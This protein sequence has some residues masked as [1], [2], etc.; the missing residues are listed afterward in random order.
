MVHICQRDASRGEDCIRL[1][2]SE[3][4]ECVLGAHNCDVNAL[5]INT[6]GSY[7]CACNRGFIGD[8]A[9]CTG[10]GPRLLSGTAWIS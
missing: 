2:V 9:N 5:C 1:H 8:G 7:R 10:K 3:T 6:V 4:D